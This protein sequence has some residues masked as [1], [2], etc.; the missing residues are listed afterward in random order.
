MRVNALSFPRSNLPQRPQPATG[1]PCATGVVPAAAGATARGECA[2]NASNGLD[3]ASA[4]ETKPCTKCKSGPRLVGQRW[5]R[6]CLSDYQR[7]SRALKRERRAQTRRQR[8]PVYHWN[9]CQ[10]Y[11][12]EYLAATRT[13]AFCC[14]GHGS[15]KQWHSADCQRRRSVKP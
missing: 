15:K 13:A 5:C 14:N 6:R 4:S 1:T 2:V 3:T 9:R 11:Q 12:C 8:P 10:A 7:A